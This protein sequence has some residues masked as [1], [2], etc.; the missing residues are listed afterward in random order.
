MESPDI[1][2]ITLTAR[3]VVPHREHSNVLFFGV[4]FTDTLGI[5]IPPSTACFPHEVTA[6]KKTPRLFGQNHRRELSH[7]P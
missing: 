6:G 4:C 7:Y 5:A 3:F 1:D 2:V